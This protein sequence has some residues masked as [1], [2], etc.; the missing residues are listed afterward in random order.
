ML[1]RSQ[2]GGLPS[3]DRTGVGGRSREG[4]FL[5]REVLCNTKEYMAGT[6]IMTL[7]I[8]PNLLAALRRRAKQEGRSV[9]AEVIRMIRKEIAP[10]PSRQRK[11][12]RT[13]GMFADFESPELDV[14]K[15]LRRDVSARV[16]K[17]L[18]ELARSA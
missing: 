14:F 7:R 18:R 2:R 15:R 8:D 6:A 10:A 11:T 4:P 9:S 16:Q 5:P 1:N 12:R 3:T 13:M 17:R